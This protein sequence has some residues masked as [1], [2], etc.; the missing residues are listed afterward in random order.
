MAYVY[1]HIR[2]D[3]NKPFYI[4]IGEDFSKNKNL[5][6]RAYEFINRNK[7]WLNIINKTK[8]KIDIILDN[9]TWE[10]ACEKE[11]EFILLYGRKDLKKGSL[12]NLTD[13][14]EGKKGVKDSIETKIKK[15]I[16]AKQPKSEKWKLSQSLNKKGKKRGILPWLVNNEERNEKI[17][18]SKLGKPSLIKKSILQYDL[19]NTLINI[20]DSILE[21]A[22]YINKPKGSPAISECCK[23]KRKQAYGYIFK[24]N[25]NE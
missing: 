12:V 6:K 4:G 8:Y 16:S 7:Y 21:A 5:Y 17:K 22:I 23:G 20:F 24:Y 11:I 19:N 25:T 3:S 10:E 2:L 18:L 9:L 13:G 14:G 1:R 15:S